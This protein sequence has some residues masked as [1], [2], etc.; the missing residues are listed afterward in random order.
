M[1]VQISEYRGGEDYIML[2]AF[3]LETRRVVTFDPDRRSGHHVTGTEFIMNG[4][5]CSD[6]MGLFQS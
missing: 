4:S 5:R 3:C 2:E 6:P 1:K